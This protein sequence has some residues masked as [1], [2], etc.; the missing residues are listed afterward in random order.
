MGWLL[1]TLFLVLVSCESAFELVY[2]QVMARHG[3]RTSYF[4]GYDPL[5]TDYGSI[6]DQGLTPV[7]MR[8]EYLLGYYLFSRY[9]AHNGTVIRLYSRSS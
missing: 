4:K 8:Q 5:D 1:L 9:N 2:F 6:P 7:G 3:A